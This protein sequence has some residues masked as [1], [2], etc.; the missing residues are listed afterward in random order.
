MPAMSFTV[1]AKTKEQLKKKVQKKIKEASKKGMSFV[2]NGYKDNNVKR[3]KG[4]YK[5]D[6]YVHS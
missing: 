1:E 6:I 5:I 4:G 3:F 2:K